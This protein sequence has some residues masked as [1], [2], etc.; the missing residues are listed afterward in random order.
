MHGRDRSELTLVRRA[1]GSRAAAATSDG[2]AARLAFQRLSA[3]CRIGVGRPPGTSVKDDAHI[4]HRCAW[5]MAA[6]LE[7]AAKPTCGPR[8]AWPAR[9]RLRNDA[10][11][12][13]PGLR[14]PTDGAGCDACSAP[15]VGPE[16]RPGR[17]VKHKWS[18]WRLAR[19]LTG[20]LCRQA[21]QRSC[22]P[23]AD[24]SV[25]AP[26]PGAAACPDPRAAGA[27]GGGPGG[28]LATAARGPGAA[29]RAASAAR[30]GPVQKFSHRIMVRRFA[31]YDTRLGP[32][33]DIPGLAGLDNHRIPVKAS[34][35]P[36]GEPGHT[37]SR[38]PDGRSR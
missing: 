6:R 7:A 20:H 1:G 29:V 10:L 14:W 37:P 19:Q 21:H 34:N 18:P 32:A 25:R 8:P 4:S 17:S 15:Q 27:C 5:P 9:A 35:P 28:S 30:H 33:A 13:Q 11:A 26:W 38:Y 16:M 23:S 24:D 3:P 36:G 22:S 12:L 2:H 31:A